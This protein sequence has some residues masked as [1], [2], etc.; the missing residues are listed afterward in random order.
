M[1]LSA[2][3]M[4]LPG[5]LSLSSTPTYPIRG[6]QLGYRPKPMPTMPGPSPNTTADIRDLALFRRQ[7]HRDHASPYRRRCHECKYETARHPNDCRTGQNLQILRTGCLDVVS[8]HEQR[9]Q[10]PDSVKAEL[11]EREKIFSILPKLDALFVPGGDPG[12]LE[13]DPLFNWLNQEA[14]VLKNIIPMPKYGYPLRL[15]NQALSGMPTSLPKSTRSRIGWEVLFM[16]RG[17]KCPCRKF[18]R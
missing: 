8:Q 12:D 9:L 11:A 17:L 18:A 2:N 10:L 15:S 3:K 5:H 13:P 6:H 14:V 1:E 16:A 7:Q 4:L